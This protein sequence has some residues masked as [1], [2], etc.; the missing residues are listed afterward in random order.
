MIDAYSTEI[1]SQ[2]FDIEYMS[3]NFGFDMQRHTWAGWKNRTCN[4]C[5]VVESNLS[6]HDH[7]ESKHYEKMKEILVDSESGYLYDGYIWSET[8]SFIQKSKYK[9]LEEFIEQSIHNKVW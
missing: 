4:T 6:K 2:D 8:I 3:F 5:P 9:E 1:W 7:S